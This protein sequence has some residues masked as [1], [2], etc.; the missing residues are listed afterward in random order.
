MNANTRAAGQTAQRNDI[1]LNL[2]NVEVKASIGQQDK[3]YVP[4]VAEAAPGM[5][6]MKDLTEQYGGCV[7]KHSKWIEGTVFQRFIRQYL[8]KT[9]QRL[10]DM[11]CHVPTMRNDP[12]VSR[13]LQGGLYANEDIAN[14]YV[15]Y[16]QGNRDW[17]SLTIVKRQNPR[18]AAVS[19]PDT[20]TYPTPTEKTP[21]TAKNDAKP[22]MK[23]Q[24]LAETDLAVTLRYLTTIYGGAA[25]LEA[26]NMLSFCY[27]AVKGQ[28]HD[29]GDTATEELL[30]A[31]KTTFGLAAN[32]DEYRKLKTA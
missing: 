10:E 13:D 4:V 29:D 7:G 14:R 1:T 12:R 8:A 31:L 6:K 18:P 11:I 16:L 5:V 24:G 15:L 3:I 32:L 27:E 26:T 17:N 20:I 30:R 23:F 21:Q 22:V 28:L 2:R 9:R 25:L 19:V